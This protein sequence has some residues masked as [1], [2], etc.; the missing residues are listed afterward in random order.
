MSLLLFGPHPFPARLVVFDKDGTL[1]DFHHLWACKTVAGVQALVHGLGGSQTLGTALYQALGYDPTADRFAPHG[2]ILT[3][4]MAKVYTIVATVLYQHGYGWLEAELAVAQHL[5][6]AMAAPPPEDQLRPTADLPDFFE[7]L[8]Q[9]GVHVGV[10]TSDDRATTERELTLLGV[11][12]YVDF[13]VGGDD[14]YPP[15]PAPEALWAACRHYRVQPQ[16]TAMV[17]DSTT[18]LLMAR[19]AGV[20]LGVGVLTGIMDQV[21]LA[22]YAD[23][24]LPSIAAIRPAS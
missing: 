7:R 21:T 11:R 15:K 13:L 3:T 23:V 19:R 22:A 18:D 17:G 14:A 1:I 12:Q 6:P 5:A 2:P 8:R 24:V 16:E 20:G 4:T 9:A 10:I